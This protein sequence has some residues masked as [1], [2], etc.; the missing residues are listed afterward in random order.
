MEQY[1]AEKRALIEQY[2]TEKGQSKG[3]EDTL[4][5]QLSEQKQSATSLQAEVAKYESLLAEKKAVIDKYEAEQGQTK[6][7]E[8]SLQ[9]QLEEQKQKNNVSGGGRGESG[10]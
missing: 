5:R 9:R 2:E 10:A 7:A 4:F 6:G 8:E 1:E 3:A